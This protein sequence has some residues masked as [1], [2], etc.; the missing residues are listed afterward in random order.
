MAAAGVAIEMRSLGLP[1]LREEDARAPAASTTL[2]STSALERQCFICLGDDKD[3]PLTRCCSTCYAAT[4]VQCWYDWRLNQ[5]I[6][7]LR[8]RLLGQRA[9]TDHFLRCSICKSGTAVLAGEEGTLGWMN[10][11]LCGSGNPGSSGLAGSLRQGESDDDELNSDLQMEDVVDKRTCLAI[12]IYIGV[13]ILVVV[14]TCALL[15]S[16]RFYAGDVI[17]CCIITLYQLS[18]LQVVSLA[19]ARRRGQMVA[20]TTAQESGSVDLEGEARNVIATSV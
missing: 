5:R 14:V 13:L 18:V 20:S 7:T 10:D 3:N 16:R 4:H 6:T 19:V 11:L 8:S 12:L 9:R 1:L 2:S 17:L 15:V